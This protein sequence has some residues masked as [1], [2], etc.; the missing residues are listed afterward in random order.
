MHPMSSGR[1]HLQRLHIIQLQPRVK[2]TEP[3]SVVSS[4]VFSGLNKLGCKISRDSF[5]IK[6]PAYKYMYSMAQQAV[7]YCG[8]I[9]PEVTLKS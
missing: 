2:N 8:R 6:T 9:H 5:K 1:R 7:N 4:R 3:E